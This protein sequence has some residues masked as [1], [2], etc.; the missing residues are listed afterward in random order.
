MAG[1]LR[2]FDGAL[3]DF[4]QPT[5]GSRRYVVHLPYWYAQAHPDEDFAETFAVWLTPGS[6]WKRDYKGS[7]A[8]RKLAYVD[9]LMQELADKTPPVKSRSRPDPL[10]RIKTTLGEHYKA[11]RARQ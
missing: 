4:Y 11:R 1:D 2:F 8:L 10:H 3:P 5:P 6:T 9:E 7:P